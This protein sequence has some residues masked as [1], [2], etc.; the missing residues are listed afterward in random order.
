MSEYYLGLMSGTSVDGIDAALVDF[1]NERPTLLYART[2]DWPETL[3]QRIL[4]ILADPDAV[5]VRAL[6]QLHAAIGEQFGSVALAAIEA[7]H[8]QREQIAAI[9]SH[10][11]TLYH[12]PDGEHPFSMQSGDANRI[13]EITGITTVA[14]FRGRDIAAGGQGAPLV[15]AFHRAV[16]YDPDVSRAILNI[17]GIANLTLLPKSA[18]PV[19]GFDTGPGNGLMDAWHQKH[20][21][22][23]FDRD[24]RWAGSGSIKQAM[25]ER[26]LDQPYFRQPPPKSTGRELFNLR[27]LETELTSNGSA[28]QAEDVQRTL[29]ELTAVTVARALQRYA[30]DTQQLLVCGGGAHNRMLMERLCALLAPVELASTESYGLHPDWVEAAAFAWLAKQTLE[31]KPGNLPEVTGARR[32][33][34]LG[35]IYPASGITPFGPVD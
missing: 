10:G 26:L 2:F 7:A 12:D 28:A 29:L 17:G 9:G 22:S 25:L 35:A 1:G 31:G 14:D 16:F 13:A 4:Q 30:P 21:Q 3:R 5:T 18:G 8:L 34:V 20:R 6:G 24:G 23:R 19:L 15:P 33:V 11:Q 27:W 32:P